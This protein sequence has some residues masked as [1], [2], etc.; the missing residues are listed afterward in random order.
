MRCSR[1]FSIVALLVMSSG[2]LLAGEPGPLPL[3]ETQ[4]GQAEVESPAIYRVS[5]SEPGVL[6]VVVRSDDG[7]DVA[8]DIADADGQTLADGY[9]DWDINGDL[10]A[11]QI[12]ST[13]GTAGD[14]LVYVSAYDGAAGFVVGATYL[15]MPE[16]ALP[17]DPN[18]RPGTAMP[19]PLDERTGGTIRPARG[20]H[21]DWYVVTPTRSGT[22]SVFTRS[23]DDLVLN[24]FAPGDYHEAMAT[25]DNDDQ[26]AL[27]NESLTLDVRRDEPIF[28]RVSSYGE[29]ADYL[30]QAGMVGVVNQPEE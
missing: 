11:E 2:P 5:V 15:A 26:E 1:I 27:G 28:F 13:L 19:L 9:G 30:V 24:A 4:R 20:D 29:A 3:G 7:L 12:A 8:V 16:A 23:E 21:Y 14:Y 17:E 25:A 18:G 22:L 6:T 10:G